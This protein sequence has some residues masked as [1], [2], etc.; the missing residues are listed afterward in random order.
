MENV[1][2]LIF[3]EVEKIKER[4]QGERVNLISFE[5]D[6]TGIRKR[7]KGYEVELAEYKKAWELI[8]NN[9]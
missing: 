1:K 7:I 5:A 2:A 3:K 9:G 6:V 8:E 4:L